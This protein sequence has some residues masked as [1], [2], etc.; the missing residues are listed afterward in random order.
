MPLPDL[1][2]Q[3][4]IVSGIIIAE[5]EYGDAGGKI[6]IFFS[7]RVKYMRS[8]SPFKDDGEPVVDM[9]EILIQCFFV[10]S[11]FHDSTSLPRLR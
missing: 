5:R 7:V 8:L 6:Q 10:F 2:R 9:Q 11:G 3:C 1:S 4:G